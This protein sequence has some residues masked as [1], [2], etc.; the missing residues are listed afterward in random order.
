[1]KT[2]RSMIII[3]FLACVVVSVSL[4]TISAYLSDADKADNSIIVGGN[5]ISIDE[6][7]E[8]EPITPGASITKKVHIYNDGPNACYVR[9][10][11]VFTDS[12][13]GKYAVID[14]NLEDWE[15]NTKDEYYYYKQPIKEGESTSYLMT[16]I[17]ISEE[18]PK[19]SIQDVN[20]IVYAESYQ[21]EG[22]LI[23]Q[24]AWE[25]FQLNIKQTER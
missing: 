18:I 23:Y 15:Y 7:Y 14:W 9:V 6:V 20:L 2:R 25:D 19:E 16:S 22:F 4:H 12:N 11:A 21:S 1:M 10:R 24:D 5:N 3:L 13:V 8:S 17:A